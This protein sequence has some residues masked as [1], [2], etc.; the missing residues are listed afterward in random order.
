MTFET[1]TTPRP[2]A[3]LHKRFEQA[4]R[5]FLKS[6]ASMKL[7][8]LE[9]GFLYYDAEGRAFVAPRSS[10]TL[11]SNGTFETGT[12]SMG[13]NMK[14]PGNTNAK[15]YLSAT[16]EKKMAALRAEWFQGFAFFQSVRDMIVFGAEN[17]GRKDRPFW[18]LTD[19]EL[20]KLD[21]KSEGFDFFSPAIQEDEIERAM[22]ETMTT[23]LNVHI[24]TEIQ[25]RESV[26]AHER[27]ARYAAQKTAA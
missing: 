14:Y 17:H 11:R 27:L 2:T 9:D 5:A 24:S 23:R 20:K 10:F 18:V 4:A 7:R 13:R 6:L 22:R 21:E 26:S 3:N 8:E 1:L 16:E 12:F 15:V 25:C 19:E